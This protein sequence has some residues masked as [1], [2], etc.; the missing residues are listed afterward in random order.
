M[1]VIYSKSGCPYCIK[2]KKVMEIEELPH[3]S[4]ELDRDF[5]KEEFYAKFGEGSTF[6]QVPLDD[7]HLGGCQESI[8]HMQR[9]KICCQL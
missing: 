9:E 1:I 4:Y 7:I 3:V 2:M 5:T 6:P 8:Q